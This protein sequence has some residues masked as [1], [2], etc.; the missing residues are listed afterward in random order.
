VSQAHTRL[1]GTATL[2]ATYVSGAT[3]VVTGMLLA[4][5]G[6]PGG[7]SPLSRASRLQSVL[8][9]A[10]SPFHYSAHRHH[11]MGRALVFGLWFVMPPIC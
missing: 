9:R 11:E 6:G 10:C 4:R 2:G 5:E 8:G 3:A 7:R 1:A